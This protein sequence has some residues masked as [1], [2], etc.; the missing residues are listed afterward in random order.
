MATTGVALSIGGYCDP[1]FEAV[2]TAFAENFTSRGELGA[3]VCA[4]IDGVTVVDLWGG[5]CDE[6]GAVAWQRDTL[7]NSYSVGKALTAMVVLALVE[8][9]D[10]S[11]DLP[12]ARWWPE[13]A[14]EDKDSL[15]LRVLMAHRG[16]LPAV[17]RE[18]PHDAM[19][20]WSLMTRELAA[21][22][23]W[24]VPDT[25]HGYHVNTYGFLLG[26]LVRRAT[27]LEF[28]RA[29][30]QLLAGPA[31]AEYYMGLT[32]E[33][34]R[35]VAPIA[36]SSAGAVTDL[37]K[38]VETMCGGTDSSRREMIFATYFNP[39]GLSG[40]GMVN[41]PEW[42]CAVIPST[43]GHAT[44]R[45]VAAIYAA[46]LAGRAGVGAT[47]R[48]EAARVHSDGEDLVLGRPSCFGLGLQLSTPERLVG[49]SPAAYGHFGY[50]GSLGFADPDARIAFGYL[51]NRPGDRWKTPRTNALVDA[52]YACI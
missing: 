35:R 48:A 23:P 38:A 24:W 19:L 1:R 9:G 14:N 20:D 50:G 29:F 44:A 12:V 42:R 18:L 47:L 49:R 34:H 3:G 13:F 11:L 10:L 40:F 39:P 26:E 32:P 36:A 22:R 8:R 46:Y 16:G 28:G 33:H 45:A 31:G 37:A 4:I 30:A 52:L 15:T 51:M 41:R 5:W 27:G 17:R 7:V 43:N 2:R 6:A 25:A 21:E